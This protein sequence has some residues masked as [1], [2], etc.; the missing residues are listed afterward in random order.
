MQY[1][2]VTLP[3]KRLVSRKDLCYTTANNKRDAY[4]NFK[5]KR[6][7][8]GRIIFPNIAEKIETSKWT[9]IEQPPKGDQATMP[10]G[11]SMVPSNPVIAPHQGEFK[12]ES[13]VKKYL[14]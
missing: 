3:E 1:A 6:N 14:K 2:L 5:R 8:Q 9:I 4:N 11:A 12:F 10:L 7:D 13:V